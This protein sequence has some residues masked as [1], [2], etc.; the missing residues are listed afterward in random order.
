MYARIVALFDRGTTVDT[1]LA[2]AMIDS[3]FVDVG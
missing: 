3:L 1:V 2:Q